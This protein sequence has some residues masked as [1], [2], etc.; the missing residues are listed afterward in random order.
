MDQSLLD[1]LSDNGL[2]EK[3]A[4]VYVTNLQLGMAPVSTIARHMRENRVTVYSILKNLISK[5]IAKSSTKKNTTY[6]SVIDPEQLAGKASEKAQRMQEIV[7]QLMAM[8][9]K[10]D[11]PVK[12][13]FFE[14]LEGLKT[15]YTQII[16]EG[17]KTMEPGE[18]FLSFTGAGSIDPNLL[19][20][21]E[22]E[23]I[24]RRLTFPRKTLAILS[25]NDS[26]YGQYTHKKHE[27]II[28]EDP[29]FDLANEI[30]VYGKDQVAILMYSSAE[31]A[32]LVI[33]SQTLHNALKSVFNIIWKTHK[34]PLKKR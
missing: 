8:A 21:L 13:Q 5:G 29:V 6:Y 34:K 31:M 1:V 10:V 17:D 26:S 27:N 28:I 3:E 16:T 24:P 23:F 9:T 20:Y 33:Q 12:T 11:A 25:G 19:Q 7:P 18:P 15:I 2:N 14:G 4:K 22:K 32:A 30:V